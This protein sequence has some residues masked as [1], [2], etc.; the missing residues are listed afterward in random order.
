MIIECVPIKGGVHISKVASMF[1]SCVASW[2]H[3]QI[4]MLWS[5]IIFTGVDSNTLTTVA[6]NRTIIYTIHAE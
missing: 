1:I 6:F 5:L 4:H 3:A 2:D